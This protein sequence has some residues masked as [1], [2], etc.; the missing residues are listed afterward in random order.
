MIREWLLDANGL[1]IECSVGQDIMVYWDDQRGAFVPLASAGCSP[2]TFVF[3]QLIDGLE[4][5]GTARARI[6]IP[7]TVTGEPILSSTDDYITV[8]DFFYRNESD[9]NIPGGSDVL[10]M[11]YPLFGRYFL[12]N[13]KCG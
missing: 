4:P 12:I 13:T 9:P 3:A 11:H 5:G 2:G 6:Y 1:G 8:H 10:V 7:H